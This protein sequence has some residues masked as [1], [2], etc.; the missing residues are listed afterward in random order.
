MNQQH[1]LALW[2]LGRLPSEELPRIA[3]EWLADGIDTPAIR[4]L[5]G[6]SSPEMPDVGPLFSKALSSTHLRELTRDE[7]LRTI[8]QQ[9]AQEIVEGKVTPHE[10]ARK[11]WKEVNLESG[12]DSLLSPFIGAASELEDLP[13]RTEKDGRDRETYRRQLNDLIISAARALLKTE[14]NQSRD[15][16]V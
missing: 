3:A 15:P 11:V 14:P 4:E 16:A 8:A 6:I 2:A 1:M 7:A 5:A 12:C 10:G 9:Y 13:D